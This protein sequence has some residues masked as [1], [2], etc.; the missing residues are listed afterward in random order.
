M[1]HSLPTLCIAISTI[2]DSNEQELQDQ[3]QCYCASICV[4]HS[5]SEL[6]TRLGNK[7]F[8]ACRSDRMRIPGFPDYSPIVAALKSSTTTSRE[9]SFRVSAQLHDRLIILEALA[10]RW[11]ENDLT[12]ERAEAMIGEHNTLYNPDGLYW[13]QERSEYL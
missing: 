10:K 9:K 11:V 13:A 12:R 7:V 8:E 6:T 5:G 4:D 1:N 2:H 3:H